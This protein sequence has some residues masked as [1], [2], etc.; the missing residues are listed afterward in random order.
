MWYV[1]LKEALKYDLYDLSRIEKMV[2]KN[3]AGDFFQISIPEGDSENEWPD[4]TP[5][6]IFKIKTNKWNIVKRIEKGRKSKPKLFW[7]L[8]EIT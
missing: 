1:T 6:K 3:I 5:F 2:L 4:N 8:I 7:F